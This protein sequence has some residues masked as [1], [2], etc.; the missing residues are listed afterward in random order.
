M[1]VANMEHV[2][3]RCADALA[4]AEAAAA[5]RQVASLLTA[6]DYAD[7]TA[8]PADTAHRIL[9]LRA[10]ATFTRL[11]R[12]SA[13]AAP[14]MTFFGAEVDPS[15]LPLE[16]IAGLPLMSASGAGLSVRAAFEG[17]VGEGVELLSQ[18]ALAADDLGTIV[19][20][21]QAAG[22]DPSVAGMA[23]RLLHAAGMDP[24][25]PIDW[26]TGCR[27]SDTA[28]VPLP[29]DLCL[30]RGSAGRLPPGSPL[31]IGC[32]AGIF[33]SDA[34]LHGLLELIERDAAALWWRG[35]ARGRLIPLD[36]PATHRSL[37][38][39]A[40]MRRGATGRRSWLLDITSDLRVP[41]IAAVSVDAAGTG[42]ACGVAAHLTMGQAAEAAIRELSQ[43]ELAHEVVAA[44][45]RESG[46]E[47]LNNADRAHLRRARD[48]DAGTCVLLHP[49]PPGEPVPDIATADPAD[50][51][52]V[53]TR[54]LRDQGI[55]T[56]LLDLTR[57]SFG[58]PVVRVIC[59]ELEREPSSLVGARLRAAI[60]HTGGVTDY[61]RDIPLM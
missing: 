9:M 11:F 29:A 55:E 61:A 39:L 60:A 58:I 24:A 13:V 19:L 17:C 38:L 15:G 48:L 22:T 30:R 25:T 44:K 33:L 53:L 18:C 16:Q 42:F 12:L 4:G 43:M 57:P 52:H 23:E 1:N 35:G 3:T 20:P 10:A 6:L 56:F 45:R 51:V 26:I 37:A 8:T 14:G 5:D 31:S 27:L 50:A 46:D 28:A 54:R 21:A 41:V 40:A 34:A 47:A 59:P 36:S 2:L 7:A 32:A 49:L